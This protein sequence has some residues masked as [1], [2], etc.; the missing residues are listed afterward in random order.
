MSTI[1][2]TVHSGNTVLLYINGKKVGRASNLSPDEDFGLEPIHEI[3]EIKPVENVATRYT[4]RVRLSKFKVIKQSLKQLGIVPTPENVL[5]TDTL[6]IT[7]IDKITNQP[8]VTL[9]GCSAATYQENFQAGAIVGE[10]ASFNYI[11][12][13]DY[14]ENGQP[15]PEMQ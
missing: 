15:L 10:D 5:K 3:G 12:R 7:M 9:R 6:E 8:L 11:S 2:Q 13:V 4:G 1:K 14:D